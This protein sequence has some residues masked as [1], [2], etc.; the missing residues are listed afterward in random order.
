MSAKDTDKQAQKPKHRAPKGQGKDPRGNHWIGT[1]PVDSEN[2]KFWENSTTLQHIEYIKL[3]EEIGDSETHYDHYQVYMV[4]KQYKK[5]SWVKKHIH[6]TAHWEIKH[7]TIAEAIDY[8]SKT[9]TRKPGGISF[10]YGKQ[11][12]EAWEKRV[13]LKLKRTIEEA[14][15]VRD[16]DEIKSDCNELLTRIHQGE[17]IDLKTIAPDIQMFPGFIQAYE[18]ATKALLGPERP[19][20]RVITIVG[21]PGCGKSYAISKL[22]PDAAK[23]MRGN[24]GHW[25]MNA[26]SEVLV[27]E[28]Y[29]GDIKLETFLKYLDPYPLSLEIKGG[30]R[31]AMYKLLIITSNTD[32]RFWY[33]SAEEMRTNPMDD[34]TAISTIKQRRTDNL[35]ALYDRLGVSHLTRTYGTYIKYEVNKSLGIPEEDQIRAM[36]A[37]IFQFLARIKEEMNKP[38]SPNACEDESDHEIEHEELPDQQDDPDLSDFIDPVYIQD[39]QDSVIHLQKS[40]DIVLPN[41]QDQIDGT[42]HFDPLVPAAAG[43]DSETEGE[44]AFNQMCQAAEQAQ[45]NMEV[46]A[47]GTTINPNDILSQHHDTEKLD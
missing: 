33:T 34:P 38:K 45:A 25:F 37:P 27:F 39:E 2:A 42:N 9:E 8:V 31:P 41:I 24:S 12:Q 4:L 16:K 17:Y 28:E 22:F 30:S 13:E 40:P 1:V 21:P 20:L 3:Q 47:Q 11:P 32:P 46:D 29:S 36:R 44:R 19:D 26:T 18:K 15:K 6:K 5:L 10:E 23:W 14:R 35:G 7:G 43:Y